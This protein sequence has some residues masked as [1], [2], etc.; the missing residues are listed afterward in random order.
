M[1]T[2][3][4]A[5]EG[6]PLEVEFRGPE[7]EDIEEMGVS[8]MMPRI[9]AHMNRWLDGRTFPWGKKHRSTW[10]TLPME[11]SLLFDL[12]MWDCSLFHFLI[13]YTKSYDVR[14]C[15]CICMSFSYMHKIYHA[16]NSR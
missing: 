3:R 8:W 11:S 6:N 4:A 7:S 2:D 14:G 10:A 15:P 9:L 16:R 13:L 1:D 12:P 5:C